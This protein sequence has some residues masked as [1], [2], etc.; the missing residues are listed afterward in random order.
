ML[1]SQRLVEEI[2]AAL[3]S[4]G[5]LEWDLL[6]DAAA[7][8]AA[9][10][11]QANERLATCAQLLRRGLRSEAL[12]LAEQEP[13]LLDAV[14]LLDFPELPEWR[15]LLS[16]NGMVLPPAL[17]IDI[18][19]DLNAAYALEAPL[20]SLLKR[21]RLLALARAPLSARI[22][23]LR[24]IRQADQVN[25][26]WA[27]D[28]KVLETARQQELQRHVESAYK[29]RDLDV[30]EAIVCEI[31]DPEWV[32]PPRPDIADF[33]RQKHLSLAASVATEQLEE[34]EPRLSAAY[35]AFDVE[36]G[37]SLRIEW[38][39]FAS[40]AALPS[41]H[42][43]MRR[44]APALAWLTEQDERQEREVNFLNAV[45]ELELLLADGADR[46]SLERAFH[47]AQRYDEEIP[48]RLVRQYQEQI[49]MFDAG[50]RRRFALTAMAVLGLL[51][52]IGGATG[53]V[54]Y[55]GQQRALVEA[56]TQGLAKLVDAEDLPEAQRYFDDVAAKQPHI[57]QHPDVQH[58]LGRLNGLLSA[59]KNRLESF[60][61]LMQ[62]IADS[63]LENPNRLAAIEAG[64]LAKTAAER[65]QVAR[66]ESDFNAQDRRRQKERDEA[67]QVR[68]RELLALAEGYEQR[69]GTGAPLAEGKVSEVIT[70]I[71]T[72]QARSGG[73]TQQLVVQ[74][75]PLEARLLTLRR[76][77]LA[78][79]AQN[80]ALDRLAGLVGNAKAYRESLESFIKTY[81]N[82][83]LTPQ[84]QRISAEASLW[85]SMQNWSKFLADE[86]FQNLA[87]ISPENAAAL[88]REGDAL[89]S[90]SERLPL[91][92]HFLSR[93]SYFESVAARLDDDGKNKVEA[94][95]TLFDNSLI[96]GLWLVETNSGERFYLTA[97]PDIDQ[98]SAPKQPLSLEPIASF[99]LSSSK[100]VTVPVGEVRFVGAAPQAGL[101]S[102][103]RPYLHTIRDGEWDRGFFAMARHV[104]ESE[105]VDPL[106]RFILLR[107]ILEV[108][109]EGSRSFRGASQRLWERLETAEVDLTANW[110]V[111]DDTASRKA[112]AQ[113]DTLLG[114]L[115]DFNTIGQ[116]TAAGLRKD[117]APLP[118][119]PVWVG[120]L[121][122]G[123]ESQWCCEPQ[124]HAKHSGD[125]YVVA[126][127]TNADGTRVPSW[128]KVAEC[129]TGQVRWQGDADGRLAAGRP[130][131]LLA[132]SSPPETA[133]ISTDMQRSPQP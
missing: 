34:L 44:A 119:I 23:V 88:L 61:S 90:S 53:V 46:V 95:Q 59:E 82:S 74:L 66:W 60:Q 123:G 84:F 68:F 93:R 62:Q 24:S 122:P 69:I 18:A 52:V 86:R 96:G 89:L 127:S 31:Q 126:F 102:K 19:S 71:Q 128:H 94:L 75:K 77:M 51:A 67:F 81:P 27:Q 41:D 8:Y 35:S 21:H 78:D 125:L 6:R 11:D 50:A 109:R 47:A 2:Q 30:L 39:R 117:I 83:S 65:A 33:A 49:R 42:P 105:R 85:E 43:L 25:P 64:K 107:R 87:T 20:Q 37:N 118:R 16:A 36:E 17:R 5:I 40:V 15:Q 3:L 13:N 57:A 132:A 80:E 76:Q 124:D 98:G 120:W 101:V 12:Q 92:E 108:G 116:Q 63:G 45:N 48:V 97:K 121:R 91:A 115:D 100:R 106:L 70:E 4:P 114:S 130:L 56:T 73:V 58:Q 7:E 112:R 99:D 129:S 38:L 1:D 54:I 104:K 10:C 14:A 111:W 9:A 131:Y 26:V 110:L 22:Q 29:A 133:T 72:L 28:L 103:C 55:R 113:A 32:H 79:R